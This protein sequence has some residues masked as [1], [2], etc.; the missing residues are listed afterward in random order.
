MKHLAS[1]RW[2]GL[3]A[4]TLVELLMVIAVIATLTT[5]PLP[6]RAREGVGTQCGLQKQLAANRH[7]PHRL[8]A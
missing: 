6:A 1:R 3:P 7:R 8:H 2:R 4:F 5:V